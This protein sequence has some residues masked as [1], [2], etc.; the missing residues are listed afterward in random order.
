MAGRKSKP[1]N[2]K[3]ISPDGEVR[4]FK[5]ICEAARELGFSERGMGKAYHVGRNR[6]GE[7]ELE[8]LEPDAVPGAML[9]EIFK[10]VPRTDTVKI[11]VKIKERSSRISKFNCIYCG[12]PLEE[13]DRSDYFLISRLDNNKDS[14]GDQIDV[15]AY[16][17]IY[18]ASRDTAIS[19]CALRNAREK[20]NTLIIRRKD[21]VPFEI[22]WSDIHPN[23]FEA[24]KEDRRIA[25]REEELKQEEERRQMMSEMTEKELAEFKRAEEEERN[26]RDIEFEKRFERLFGEN[27][28]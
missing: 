20:G 27:E 18:E 11:K 24:R 21:K 25:E 19:R 16:N 28:Y 13:K 7:Y 10:K 8:W 6:I 22:D 23:C 4:F 3:S 15:K 26:R 17:T 2:L 1:I 14:L 9:T 12:Q 5:T